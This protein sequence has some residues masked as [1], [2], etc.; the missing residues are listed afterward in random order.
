MTQRKL[1]LTAYAH[2]L[3]AFEQ[4]KIRGFE[5]VALH[6]MLFPGIEM[7]M[8]P[9]DQ[10]VEAVASQLSKSGLEPTD[11]VTFNT[12]NALGLSGAMEQLPSSPLDPEYEIVRRRGVTQFTKLIKLCRK[13]GCKQIYSQMGGRPLYHLDHEEAWTKSVRELDPVLEEEGVK[14]AFM[15]HPGDFIEES[16]PCV[17]LIKTSG[18][19]NIKYIYV[20]PHSYVLAGRMEADP[21]EMIRYAADK[22]VLSEIHMADSIKP[23]QAWIR[24]HLDIVSLHSHL[25]PGRGA[26]NI[27]DIVK[28]L[29]DMQFS[30][31]IIMIAYRYGISDKS[32]VDLAVESK[33]YVQKILDRV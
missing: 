17:D 9:S 10:A 33:D 3:E 16:N 7:G 30:G 6:P 15:P 20:V 27:E 5:Y 4:L 12:W 19:E 21:S 14:L 24:D 31:P 29:A 25:I 23:V 22:G 32:F 1:K 26:L 28:T 2:S 8:I 18:S 11:L 13:F